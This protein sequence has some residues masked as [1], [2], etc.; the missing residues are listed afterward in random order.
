MMCL[1]AGSVVVVAEVGWMDETFKVGLL[2]YLASLGSE[3]FDVI[4][5]GMVSRGKVGFSFLSR[6]Y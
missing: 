2:A 1:L 5:H 6:Y 4:W 3:E